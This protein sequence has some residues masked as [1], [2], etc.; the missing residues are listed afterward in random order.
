MFKSGDKLCPNLL[1]MKNNPF[2][3]LQLE[4][5]SRHKD[6]SDN[7]DHSRYQINDFKGGRIL[8]YNAPFI[9]TC[10]KNDKI[11]VLRNHSLVI[12]NGFIT[13]IG[14]E[15]EIK[16]DGFDIV[17]DAS[18]RGGTVLTPGFI[19]AHSHPP[20]YLMRSA[21]M[22]GEEKG[23]DETIVNMPRWER[24][25]TDEDYLISTIGDITEQQK[26]GVT[27]TLSHYG[28][29]FPIEYAALSTGQN[30]INAL[31]VASN[32]HPQNSPDL[33][34]K[35]LE[36]KQDFYSQIAIAIHYLYKASPNILKEISQLV[37]KNNLLFTCHLAESE[38]VAKA[39]KKEHGCREVEVLEKYGLLNKNTILSHAIHIENEE[40]KKIIDNKVG[41]AHLPTSNT[42]HKSGTFPFWKFY[43]AQGLPYLSLG[44]DSVISKSR[45]DIISE[46]YQ[47]R[48]THLY[49]RTVKF[50][51]LFKMMTA[52]GARVLHLNDRGK[53]KVGYRADLIFWKL[54]DR[55]S[56]PYNENN[57][58]TLI[59]NIITHGGRTVRDL[60]INGKFIIKN[61]HH[62][63]IDETKLLDQL[64]QRHKEMR[65]KVNSN[66]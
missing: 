3:K 29:F 22:L 45:L 31:S 60:M 23:I 8:I 19:N 18:K 5:S 52:N 63:L 61:R 47:T 35:L 37:Q 55:G 65:K 21:T 43:D 14:P 49:Q 57:P 12:E 1:I 44:T 48:L 56:I 24:A 6:H 46:A 11:Q 4:L 34:K 15:N 66:I 13:K 2:Q 64:Q 20:M 10:D 59:G 27:T 30:V 40:I 36:N 42:I 51:S 50:G 39:C 54:R 28:V 9:F 16:Q 41:I 17:Y 7:T 32:T 33:I 25:M 38:M 62:I 26:Y 58:I 53:I